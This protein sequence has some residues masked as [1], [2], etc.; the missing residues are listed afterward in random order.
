MAACVVRDELIRGGSFKTYDSTLGQ[1]LLNDP[2]AV[3]VVG[4]GAISNLYATGFS[5]LLMLGWLTAIG[6]FFGWTR[7]DRFGFGYLTTAALL[8]FFASRAWNVYLYAWPVCNSF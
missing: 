2:D 4:P 1:T 8:A 7:H 6:F 5:T 3:V